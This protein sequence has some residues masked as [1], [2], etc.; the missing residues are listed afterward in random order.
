MYRSGNQPLDAVSWVTCGVP[1]A[2]SSA[3]QQF[4]AGSPYSPM[5]ASAGPLPSGPGWAFE[6]KW[7]GVR[8]I[9]D[10]RGG[11]IRV[12]ARSG[13]D[14]TVAYPELARPSQ[15]GTDA[16]LDGELV[17]FGPDGRPSFPALI[18]RLHVRDPG[19]AKR[20]AAANPVTFL[21]FDLLRSAGVDLCELPYAQRRARLV[22]LDVARLGLNPDTVIVPPVF[23]DGPAT[24]AASRDHGLE[25]VV[26]KRLTARYRPGIRSA[27]WVKIK[28]ERTDEFVVGG[29]RPGVRTIGSLLVGAVAGHSGAGG[30]P[31]LGGDELSLVFRG[32]V[33]SGIS[34]ATEREL[35]AVLRPLVTDAS[36]FRGTI[37]RVDS[38]GAVWVRPE[39]IV[40]VR[41]DHQTEA[42]RLRFPRL[43]RLRPDKHIS[44]YLPPPDQ[45]VDDVP[46]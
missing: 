39:V 44:E 4:G 5:L 23:D 24:L 6:L 28:F 37:A 36:P 7:D 45:E 27:D 35:L 14:A 43:V 46:S 10:C 30:Q 25:G 19:R 8:A 31:V 18:E 3:G 33:G 41:F 21:V 2:R 29:W 1:S 22:A 38:K 15:V 16:V 42:G 12:Y 17:I 13:T 20:L 26:A 34:A 40:E 32:R 11:R 9:A